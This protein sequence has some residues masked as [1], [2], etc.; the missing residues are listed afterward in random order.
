VTLCIVH[1]TRKRYQ[2]HV[3]LPSPAISSGICA[4][5]KPRGTLRP[6]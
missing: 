6:I 5:R 4:V 2:P 3:P 1:E